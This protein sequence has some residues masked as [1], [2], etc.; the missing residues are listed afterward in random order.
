MIEP[1]PGHSFLKTLL[2]LDIR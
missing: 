2:P 1:I